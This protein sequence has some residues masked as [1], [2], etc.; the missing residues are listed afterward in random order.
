MTNQE[1]SLKPLYV[2]GRQPLRVSLNGPALLLSGDAR[3]DRRVPLQRVS[4][5]VVTGDVS[6]TTEALLACADAGITVCFVRNHGARARLVGRTSA[7][8]DFAQLWSDFVD[9]PDWRA[10]YAEWHQG[11]RSR[12]IR[13][14]AFRLGYRWSGLRAVPE[15]AL[16]QAIAGRA[17]TR[18]YRTALS[19]VA[20]AR[21][22]EELTTLGL[23][24][25]NTEAL[26]IVPS[27]V[28]VLQWALHPD[29]VSLRANDPRR[30]DPVAFFEQQRRTVEYHLREA[31][32]LLR[33]H[34]E[35][36][37]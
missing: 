30:S 31:T 2:D 1:V 12:A 8:C 33:R 9:R 20:H 3:A 26:R 21:A 18:S 29:F 14:C 23:S 27:L 16:C 11:M 35:R 10:R 6:W 24:A 15:A 22:V 37:C 7:I 25:A 19:G 4:R 36:L 13:F 17:E 5:V 34:L 28:M 32:H